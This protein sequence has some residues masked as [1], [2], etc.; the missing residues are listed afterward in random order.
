MTWKE[1]LQKTHDVLGTE[2]VVI[3]GTQITVMTLVVLA[4][5]VVVTFKVAGL[6]QRTVERSLV[7]RSE[8]DEGTA[9]VVSRLLRYVILVIGL[10]IGL[11]TA[12]INLSALF[13]AGALFAVAIGFAMQNV[14]ANFVSGI[15]LLAERVIKP[16]DILEVEGHMVRVHDM[17]IRATLVRTLDDEDLVLPNSMLVQSTVKN[18]TLQD[19]LYR[20]RV[21]VGVSYASDL[22]KVRQALESAAH[23]VDWRSPER[24]PVVLL[25]DFGSSSVDYEVSVWIEDPWNNRTN[26]SQLREAMWWALKEAGITIAYPQVDVHFDEPVVEGIRARAVA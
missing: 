10:S 7:K 3:A 26:R 4:A 21:P 14:V 24:P 6:L 23:S 20:L 13:A 15:I 2:L 5:I 17:G 16:G 1:V 12:G 11:H 8:G 9:G 25:A 19:R 18:F 22:R